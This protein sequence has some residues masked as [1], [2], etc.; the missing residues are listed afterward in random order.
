MTASTNRFRFTQRALSELKPGDKPTLYYDTHCVGLGVRLSPLGNR[1]FFVQ[2]GSRRRTLK[3]SDLDAARKQVNAA[4]AASQSDGDVAVWTLGHLFELW[5]E[6]KAR[7][8][9]RTWKRDQSRWEQYLK[10][11]SRRKLSQITKLDVIKLRNDIR[12]KSGPYAANDTVAFVKSLYN[13]AE[14]FDYEGRNP[15]AKIERFAEQERERYLLPEEFPRWYK[16][17]QGLRYTVARDFFLLALWTG[18]RR[19]AVLSMRWEHIDLEAGTWRLPAESDKGKRDLVLY[20]SEEAIRVLRARKA[21][22]R[23]PWV[24]PSPNGSGSGHYADPKAS[25]QKVLAASGIKDL[26]IHDLRRTLGSWMAEGGSNLHVIGKVLGHKS[27][28]ATRIY[29]RLGGTA[30]RIAVNAATEAMKSTLPA[31]PPI[32]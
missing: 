22:A 14:T 11:W 16:A 18:I 21:H 12:D 20:L 4:K 26:R 25:W 7:P 13:Y 9:K 23:G 15:A 30:V 5:M 28:Q 27:Q 24:L 6:L 1:S 19:E 17:V 3:T 29:A 2:D 8:E 10:P 32:D 31:E